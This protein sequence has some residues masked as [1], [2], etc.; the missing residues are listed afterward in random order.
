MIKV[1]GLT[2]RYGPRTAIEKLNFDIPKGVICGFLGPNGAGKTTTMKILTCTMPASEGTAEIAGW[3]VFNEPMGVKRAVGYLPET[4]PVY[5]EMPVQDY[6]LF[7]ARLHEVPKDQLKAAVDRA[8]E[9]T[10]LTEVRSRIIGNL[11]KG[12]RQR[13]GLA[14]AIVHN[15]KVLILDEPTVG[16]DPVQIIEIRNLI[17][18]FGGEHT[19]IF[20]SHILSEVQATCE[21]VIMIN[22][23][24]I[25][26]R[27][28]VSELAPNGNLEET[29]IR[30]VMQQ[31]GIHT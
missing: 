20:S 8:I 11:S 12:Y 30:L 19:V 17:K 29:F 14:Q 24:H 1:S 28:T 26:A 23:G 27:G 13:V 16:L 5:L 15:P 18:S 6:V 22:R 10:G 7:A 31:G 4:P 3:D 9:R 2:K 25:I 21:Q